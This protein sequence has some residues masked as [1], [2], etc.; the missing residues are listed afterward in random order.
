MRIV[1]CGYNFQHPSDFKIHRP[2]GSGNYLLLIVR[3]PAF[4]LFENKIHYTN[5]NAVVIYEKDI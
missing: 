1:N 4:F 3:S 2:N 5:G